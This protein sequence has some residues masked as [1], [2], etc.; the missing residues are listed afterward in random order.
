MKNSDLSV[1]EKQYRKNTLLIGSVLLNLIQI[2]N[3]T[4]SS[5]IQYTN[6]Y[7]CDSYGSTI[8]NSV[9]LMFVLQWRIMW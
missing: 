6:S 4:N 2:Q 8:V 5:K 3:E 9:F 7:V 1:E